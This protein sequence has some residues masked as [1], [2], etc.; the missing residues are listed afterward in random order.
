MEALLPYELMVMVY[1]MDPGKR[2]KFAPVF[3]QL[4]MK[5]VFRE[6]RTWFHYSFYH[7]G[8]LDLVCMEQV[9]NTGRYE[10][11]VDCIV[12]EK[13]RRY[14]ILGNRPRLPF[15]EFDLLTGRSVL[16]NAVDNE[17]MDELLEFI[18]AQVQAP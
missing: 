18:D 4:Q 11:M 2:E 16:Q 6:V 3:H 9:D 8:W 5:S 14:R 13:C 15:D 10:K 7:E 1:Q 12:M 17:Q